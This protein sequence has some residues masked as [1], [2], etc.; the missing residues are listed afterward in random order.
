VDPIIRI[1]TMRQVEALAHEMRR[2]MAIRRDF[3]NW[4]IDCPQDNIQERGRAPATCGPVVKAV[5]RMCGAGDDAFHW[6][7]SVV[8][9]MIQRGS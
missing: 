6:W 4:D 2:C 8:L 1:I 7:V 9:P 3:F 5:L